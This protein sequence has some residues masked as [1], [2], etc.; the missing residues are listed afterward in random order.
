[1]KK[2]TLSGFLIALASSIALAQS[3]RDPQPEQQLPQPEKQ[4]PRPEVRQSKKESKG[5]FLF[6]GKKK[7][8]AKT[9]NYNRY[10]DQK[11][12]EY[13]K[14]MEEAAKR[15][16]KMQK[17]MQKPQYSDPLYFGHKKKPKKRPPGKKKFCEECG[18]V[19]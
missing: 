5:G 18:I 8:K 13:Y 7:K 11:V 17:E 10:Y 6:F 15:Y 12:K 2:L 4:M 14:R 3:S 19:H 1:M 16:K 9:F